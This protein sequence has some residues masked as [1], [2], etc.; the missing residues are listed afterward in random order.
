MVG[1]GAAVGVPVG[2]L[3]SLQDELLTLEVMVLEAHPAVEGDEQRCQLGLLSPAFVAE[4][5][6]LRSALHPDGADV[7]QSALLD[8]GALGSELQT[9]AL[10][11]FLLEHSHLWGFR[12]HYP[13]SSC[14]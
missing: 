10:E 13:A 14:S 2:V 5:A 8:V 9:L 6:D 7:V 4:A 3:P 1:E 12:E 11:M